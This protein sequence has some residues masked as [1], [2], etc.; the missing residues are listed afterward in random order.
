LARPAEQVKVRAVS[1]RLAATPRAKRSRMQ[2]MEKS[3]TTLRRMVMHIPPLPY[4]RQARIRNN[5][6][7][8]IDVLDYLKFAR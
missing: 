5:F 2:S 3:A 6:P 1:A 8:D 7:I 4:Y